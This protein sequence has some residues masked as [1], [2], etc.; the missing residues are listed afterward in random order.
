MHETYREYLDQD[1]RRFLILIFKDE[2]GYLLK[3]FLHRVEVYQF[4]FEVPE[5]EVAM[6]SGVSAPCF[7][8]FI[9][10]GKDWI[11]SNY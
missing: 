10:S 3:V 4:R 11:L 7:E 1:D 2:R 9:K 5:G 6:A 8:K